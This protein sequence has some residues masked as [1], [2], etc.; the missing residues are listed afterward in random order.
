MNE[1]LRIV[2]RQ[3]GRGMRETERGSIDT[4]RHIL[5]C[6]V[7]YC[8]MLTYASVLRLVGVYFVL[9]PAQ[10]RA[11][12][13]EQYR[14]VQNRSVQYH[15][16]QLMKYKLYIYI[17]IYTLI[18]NIKSLHISSTKIHTYANTETRNRTM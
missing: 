17:Y 1:E 16:E 2:E 5:H 7:L 14:T 10:Q 11:L 9:T 18:K 13:P 3:S 4:D 12:Q 6:T 15:I 8:T